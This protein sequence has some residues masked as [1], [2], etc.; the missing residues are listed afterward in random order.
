MGD[1]I[2]A[3]MQVSAADLL[4]GVALAGFSLKIKV[5]NSDY[6]IPGVALAGLYLSDYR[7]T[8]SG[9]DTRRSTCGIL[10]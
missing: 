5:S 4:P 3:H 8:F 10:S 6:S 2:F 7:R 9:F 1:S